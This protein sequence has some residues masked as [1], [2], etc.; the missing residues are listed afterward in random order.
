MKD[1]LYP[2]VLIVLCVFAL[3]MA[4]RADRHEKQEMKR[5]AQR[6]ATEAACRTIVEA[7]LVR[8]C[9]LRK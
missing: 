3:A 4:M 6:I 1:Y 8:S 7:G 9:T 2:L 5:E